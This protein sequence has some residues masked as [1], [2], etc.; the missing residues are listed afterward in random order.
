M[1][2]IGSLS[3]ESEELCFDGDINT[4]MLYS[5]ETDIVLPQGFVVGKI[6]HIRKQYPVK[7][8]I[9]DSTKQG[10]EDFAA[11][12]WSI[13][14]QNPGKVVTVPMFKPWNSS[15]VDKFTPSPK[16]EY[17]G[18][19]YRSGSIEP[20]PYGKVYLAEVTSEVAGGTSL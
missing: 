8:V 16:G 15:N 1:T 5:M 3:L 20:I 6:K 2:Q 18:L 10:R 11:Q 7:Q 4:I 9:H 17:E 19:G 13:M 12:L 14:N